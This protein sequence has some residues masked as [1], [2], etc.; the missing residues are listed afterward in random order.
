VIYEEQELRDLLDAA[1]D[2]SAPLT[3]RRN[4]AYVL[5]LRLG[6]LGKHLAAEQEGVAPNETT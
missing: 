2:P 1:L 6:V 4:A 3:D 5:T